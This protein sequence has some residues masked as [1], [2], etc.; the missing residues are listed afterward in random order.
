MRQSSNYE[1]AGESGTNHGYLVMLL[2]NWDA[3]IGNT[4]VLRVPTREGGIEEFIR[5]VVGDT[6]EFCHGLDLLRPV[7]VPLDHARWLSELASQLSH[8]QVRRAFAASR[9]GPREIDGLS[10]VVM[11]RFAQLRAAIAGTG[12][13]QHEG[14][15]SAPEPSTRPAPTD[16]TREQARR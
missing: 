14:C 2:N 12:N 1:R 16:S 9:A 4:R 7:S 6:L 11:R 3:R 13:S 5:G 8:A 15:N 10:T